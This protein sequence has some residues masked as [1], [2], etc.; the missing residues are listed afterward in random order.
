[1][2]SIE[3][4]NANYEVLP[5]IVRLEGGDIIQLDGGEH[6]VAKVNECR[7]QVLPMFKRHIRVEDKV[8]GKTAEFD[9]AGAPKDIS[10]TTEKRLVLERTGEAGLAE[11]VSKKPKAGRTRLEVGDDLTH[12]GVR[13]TVFAVT[14]KL[15]SVGALDGREW[16]LDREV[17]DVVFAENLLLGGRVSPEVREQNLKNFL[18]A[19]KP[20]VARAESGGENKQQEGEEVMANKKS[21]SKKKGTTPVASGGSCKGISQEIEKLISAGKNDNQV[22]EIIHKDFPAATPGWVRKVSIKKRAAVKA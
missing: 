2:T 12:A 19:R 4:L 1:M 21:D 11:F 17:N 6:I 18:A 20:P 16:V 10:T 14:A 13:C 8:T 7:A 22:V 15:V 3:R 9:K 5:G